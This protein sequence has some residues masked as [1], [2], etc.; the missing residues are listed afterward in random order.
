MIIIK[1]NITVADILAYV[2]HPWGFM[3]P[4][5][6]TADLA[7]NKSHSAENTLL[8]LIHHLGFCCVDGQH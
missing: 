7:D 2:M 8:E 6:R 4:T 1:E 5:W 3:D